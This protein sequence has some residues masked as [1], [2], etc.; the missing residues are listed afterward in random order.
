MAGAWEMSSS[1]MSQDG[2][3]LSL[4]VLTRNAAAQCQRQI[5]VS[6]AGYTAWS[7]DFVT[8]QNPAEIAAVLMCAASKIEA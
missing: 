8:G 1:I 4:S 6:S 2:Q 5:L 3:S 7:T